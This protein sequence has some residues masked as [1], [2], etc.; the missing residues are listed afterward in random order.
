MKNHILNFNDDEPCVN[1]N[2]PEFFFE[3]VVTG[4]KD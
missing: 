4:E 3:S 2:H 1:K